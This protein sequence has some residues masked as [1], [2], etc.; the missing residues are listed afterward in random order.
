MLNSLFLFALNLL[1]NAYTLFLETPITTLNSIF[2]KI[3][4]YSSTLTSLL[5]AVYFI[6]GKGLVTFGI[7]IGIAIITIKLVFAIINL[8]GQFVP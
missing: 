7:G 4:D 3:N 5:Q 1:D 8:V 2:T 6:C